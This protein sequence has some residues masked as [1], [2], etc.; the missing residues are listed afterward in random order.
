M[1]IYRT[2]KGNYENHEEVEIFTKKYTVNVGGK[3]DLTCDGEKFFGEPDKAPVLKTDIENKNFPYGRWSKDLEGKINLDYDSSSNTG[4]RAQLE[5]I[6]YFQLKVNKTIPVGTQIKFKLWDKD[7]AFFMDSLNLDDDDFGIDGQELFKTGTVVD[8]GET[9]YNRITIKLFLTPKWKEQLEK[10]KGSF[11]DGCLDFYWKW[12]YQNTI[13]NSEEII[14]SVYYKRDLYINHLIPSKYELPE[15]IDSE[16]GDSILYLFEETKRLGNVIAYEGGD[17]VNDIKCDLKHF[18]VIQ[19]KTSSKFNFTKNSNK[20]LKQIYEEQYNIDT[21]KSISKLKS[22]TIELA[23][24]TLKT[25]GIQVYTDSEIITESAKKFFD[26]FNRTDIK[27]GLFNVVQ[28]GF[29]VLGY[30]D[31]YNGLSDAIAGRKMAT[32]DTI[33]IATGAVGIAEKV[34]PKMAKSVVGGIALPKWV[35]PVMFSYT[36]L[37]AFV[38]EPY[39]QDIRNQMDDFYI[40]EMEKAKRKGLNA[41]EEIFNLYPKMKEYYKLEK[42]INI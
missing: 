26:Y 19:I 6:V 14:L 37:E 30:L 25:G 21:G 28:A 39:L 7:V 15:I 22:E 41:V 33:G 13:W 12:E 2:S 3:Y 20:I 11:K 27:K 42:Y 36:L 34:A 40:T 8:V 38:I 4:Y 9:D 31:Y 17:V 32:Y 10:E 5:D 16:S 29:E 24:F 35:N 23:E 1:T 18:Y